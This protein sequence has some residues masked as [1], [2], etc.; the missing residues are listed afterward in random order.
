MV[1][2]HCLWCGGYVVDTSQLH[3]FV[4]HSFKSKQ[5]ASKWV[6]QAKKDLLLCFDCVEVYYQQLDEAISCD[7]RFQ[8]DIVR[9]LVYDANFNRT[10]EHFCAALAKFKGK[11][12]PS[13]KDK[14]HHGSSGMEFGARELYGRIECSI[15]EVLKHPRL[16]LTKD[17]M[18]V[19]AKIICQLLKANISID[20]GE[21]FPGVYLFL[22]HPIDEV[23]I[24]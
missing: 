23:I 22:V 14:H 24:V 20:V 15:R 19:F 8:V 5:S 13:K 10:M 3:T 1:P 16:L 7:A 21:K 2:S 4:M 9:E 6:K 12:L 17:L 11:S 18:K